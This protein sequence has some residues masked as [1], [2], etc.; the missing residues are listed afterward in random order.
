MSFTDLGLRAEI[1]RA[2]AEEGYTEPTPI[3]LDFSRFSDKI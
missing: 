2:I 1:L 3:H